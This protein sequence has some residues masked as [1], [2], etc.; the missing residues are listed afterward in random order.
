M[1]RRLLDTKVKTDGIK[2]E[3]NLF[4]C[5]YIDKPKMTFKERL[6]ILN[7]IAAK[8]EINHAQFVKMVDTR[9]VSDID[10][11]EKYFDQSVRTDKYEGLVIRNVDS[12]Y[13]V[14]IDTEKRSYN[15]LKYKP[16]P[17]SEWPVVG[18]RD[19]VEQ[20]EGC[21]HLGMWKTD[22]G[23]MAARGLGSKTVNCPG[24]TIGRRSRSPRTGII[25]HGMKSSKC[26]PTTQHSS[27]E[28][29]WANVNDRVFH[30]EYRPVASATQ[31]IP[32]SR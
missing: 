26:L 20:R 10:E 24:S 9:L 27:R 28:D 11:L 14:G 7:E 15:A 6:D 31:S 16:R 25:R 1:S 32:V 29:L 2:L 5:F 13:E 8:L 12:G 21:G 23:Y 3:Y 19:G 30:I 18:F 4:D 22:E 17:D